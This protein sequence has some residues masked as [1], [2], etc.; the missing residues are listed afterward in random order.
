MDFVQA[1]SRWRFPV[2]SY[3]G[4]TKKQPQT[5]GE[6]GRVKYK[7]VSSVIMISRSSY[8]AIFMKGEDLIHTS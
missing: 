6:G 8:L 5:D 2:G 7:T 1:Q 3:G 4:L